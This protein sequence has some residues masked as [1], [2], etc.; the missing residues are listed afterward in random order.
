LSLC[1]INY[2]SSHED[3]WGWRYSLFSTLNVDEWSAS[4]PGR[5]ISAERVPNSHW[6]GGW[7]GPR[8]GPDTNKKR[9]ISFPAENI[10]PAVKP[11]ARRY[12]DWVVPAQRPINGKIKFTRKLFSYTSKFKL[13]WNPFSSFDDK[14]KYTWAN[15]PPLYNWLQ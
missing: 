7:V 6:I 4:R 13:H 15:I 12:G 2:A 10:T 3:V 14:H 9:K 11:V 8:A 5:F 1:L